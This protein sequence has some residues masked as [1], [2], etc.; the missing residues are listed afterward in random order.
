MQLLALHTLQDHLSK[1]FIILFFSYSA[2][3]AEYFY[4]LPHEINLT[5]GWAYKIP[6]CTVLK[7]SE[8]KSLKD[9]SELNGGKQCTS[10]KS[11]EVENIQTHEKRQAK[12][13]FLTFPNEKKCNA[14]RNAFMSDGE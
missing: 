13:V 12:L 9:C 4:S 3:G 2:L 1:Y 6:K 14:D 10:D 7:P 11:V 8:K 5:E